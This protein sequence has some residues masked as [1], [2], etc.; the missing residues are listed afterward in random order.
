MIHDRF[1]LRP[2]EVDT[3]GGARAAADLISK[4]KG[5]NKQSARHLQFKRTTSMLFRRGASSQAVGEPPHSLSLTTISSAGE[6]NMERAAK[7]YRL[8][9]NGL[10]SASDCRPRP[11]SSAGAETEAAAAAPETKASPPPEAP[12]PI[13]AAKEAAAPAAA[14][15]AAAAEVAEEVPETATALHHAVATLTAA[16]SDTNEATA[17]NGVGAGVVTE[18]ARA[19]QPSVQ[20]SP[21]LVAVLVE[22]EPPAESTTEPPDHSTVEPPPPLPPPPPPPPHPVQ[23]QATAPRLRHA[24]ARAMSSRRELTRGLRR[25]GRED[26]DEGE[27]VSGIAAEEARRPELLTMARTPCEYVPRVFRPKTHDPRDCPSR[28]PR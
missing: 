7:G 19:R 16:D 28:P 5:E 4:W 13:P 2:V 23:V 9:S 14:A 25:S 1:A 12:P 24:L 18:R 26:D 11:V 15:V 3:R 27:I 10:V 6:R 8:A 21:S 20:L 17:S 22:G